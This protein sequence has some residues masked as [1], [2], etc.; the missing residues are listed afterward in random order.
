MHVDQF[1][2]FEK[3]SEG[4]MYFEMPVIMPR[5]CGICPVSHHLVSAKACDGV[6]GS[7]RRV[8]PICCVS[9]Y[10]WAR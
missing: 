4:R 8:R 10:T 3:F 9:C 5:I 6:A 2:G 7:R 1:R